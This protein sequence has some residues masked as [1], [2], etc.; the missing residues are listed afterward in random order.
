MK[1]MKSSENKIFSYF[2][3]PSRQ[4][5]REVYTPSEPIEVNNENDIETGLPQLNFDPNAD[6]Y[7][8][9]IIVGFSILTSI[10]CCNVMHKSNKF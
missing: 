1:K 8:P 9:P 7:Q 5:M 3:D 10:Q 4:F 2:V 6:I